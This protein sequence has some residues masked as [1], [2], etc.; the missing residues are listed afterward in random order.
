VEQDALFGRI[1]RQLEARDWKEAATTLRQ[2]KFLEKL[3]EEI[4]EAEEGM[5][6]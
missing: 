1:E 6:S 2:L 4:G 5:D 3:S